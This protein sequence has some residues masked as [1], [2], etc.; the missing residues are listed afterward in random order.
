MFLNTFKN[1]YVNYCDVFIAVKSCVT[2]DDGHA[3]AE[4]RLV[5][6]KILWK[7]LVGK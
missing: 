1:I 6:N 4:T 3:G 7:K 5:L 2:T